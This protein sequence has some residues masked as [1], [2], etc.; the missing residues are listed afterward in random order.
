MAKKA[1]FNMVVVKK[2]LFWACVPLGLIAA[3]ATGWM[4]IGSIADNMDKEK[5]QLE[6]QKSAV[7]TLLTGASKHPNQGTIDAIGEEREKLAENVLDAWV[8]M[9]KKQ[10]DQNTWDEVAAAA[11]IEEIMSKNFLDELT[12]STRD[13]YRDFAQRKIDKLLD[14]S[15][16]RRVE[17]R[18][19]SGKS[20]EQL[21]LTSHSSSGNS[22]G[23]G[24]FRSNQPTESSRRTPTSPT[25]PVDPNARL[26]GKVVWNNPEADL[27]W[28]MKNW[29]Q[30]SQSYE[31]WLTQEDFWVYK[32]LLWVIAESN[33][34]SR[35]SSKPYVSSTARTGTSGVGSTPLNMKDSVV[36]EI[37]DLSIGKK[38]TIKLE[39]RSNRRIGAGLGSGLDSSSGP[40]SSSG[41]GRG[42]SSGPDGGMGSV[43]PK[44]DAMSRRYVDADGKPLMDIDMTRPYRRMPVYLHLRVDQRRI[45]DVLVNCANCPMPIDV[46]WVTICPDAVKSFEYVSSTSTGTTEGGGDTGSPSFIRRPSRNNTNEMRRS[47]GRSGGEASYDFGPQA[48]EIEILGCINIFAPPDIEKIG[49]EKVK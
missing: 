44:T 11:A 49:G 1:E 14:E 20:L 19:G 18:D 8:T 43:D 10:R 5:K 2:Y 41:S 25:G 30:R 47:P 7:A 36:Q 39:E 42:G 35:E 24:R 29:Q 38:A 22:G 4:A 37:I 48:V 26:G 16:I 27:E 17:P 9:E 45:A 23:G 15:N 13:S 3:V 34:D 31:V 40:D 46:L 21:D 32:A 33:K 12:N 6:S 28:A